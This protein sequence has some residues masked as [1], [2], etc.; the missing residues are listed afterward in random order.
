M[1]FGFFASA[2]FEETV[3]VDSVKAARSA[4]AG[5]G[6]DGE[7]EE[8]LGDAVRGGFLPCTACQTR[9]LLLRLRVFVVTEPVQGVG[10]E[11]LYVI[12]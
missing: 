12:G 11:C 2:I 3:G 10:Q 1:I 7:E 8:T 9:G 4:P 6:L 5:L